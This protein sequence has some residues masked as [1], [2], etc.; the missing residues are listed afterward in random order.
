MQAR[1]IVTLNVE[2]HDGNSIRLKN[3]HVGFAEIE[4]QATN[5]A[6]YSTVLAFIGQ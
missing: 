1:C 3:A 5:V 2:R 4:A 6:D